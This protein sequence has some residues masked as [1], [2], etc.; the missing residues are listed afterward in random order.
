MQ[1]RVEVMSH[2]EEI[3]VPILYLSCVSYL[4]PTNVGGV[5]SHKGISFFAKSMPTIAAVVKAQRK[6]RAN[7]EVEEGLSVQSTIFLSMSPPVSNTQN[8][9]RDTRNRGGTSPETM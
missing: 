2:N 7:S 4:Q 9:T 5:N 3:L 6:I 8:L 1:R